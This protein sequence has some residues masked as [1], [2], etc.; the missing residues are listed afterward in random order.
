MTQYNS[1]IVLIPDYDV[2][3]T[4]L[5]AGGGGV[6]PTLVETVIRTLVPAV[7]KVG[8]DQAAARYAGRYE[9]AAPLNSSIDL[10][11]QREAPGLKIGRWISNGSDFLAE[12]ARFFGPPATQ[13][14][15]GRELDVRLYP[16]GLTDSSSPSSSS[17]YR[18]ESFRAVFQ[19][20][21]PG[22][23]SSDSSSAEPFFL[24]ACSSWGALDGL[25]YGNNSLDDF[26][27]RSDERDGSIVGLE[28]RALRVEL[29]KL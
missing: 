11:V 6:L 29:R 10:L 4:V 26:V 25:V 27:F 18:E 21:R 7:E 5:V 9:A 3:F 14:G 1:G 28:A 12:Y 24:N 23:P 20:V 17:K 8:R 22:N 15:G 16:T 19:L 2:G 13:G